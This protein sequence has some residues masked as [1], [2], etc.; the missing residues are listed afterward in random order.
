MIIYVLVDREYILANLSQLQNPRIL[1]VFARQR[2][3]QSLAM[4]TKLFN[5]LALHDR[6][7]DVV[8]ALH[9]VWVNFVWANQVVQD[10]NHLFLRAGRLLIKNDF[11]TSF[12]FNDVT[13]E[14]LGF[15]RYNS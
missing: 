11:A 7:G 15:W 4:F 13:G 14:I 1:I 3:L 9:W 2:I 12:W 8:D 10:V 5:A 6:V